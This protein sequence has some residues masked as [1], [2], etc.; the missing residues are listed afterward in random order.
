MKTDPW[1]VAKAKV[2]EML[3]D[4]K[5]HFIPPTLTFILGERERYAHT[6][7]M[8]LSIGAE[9][10]SLNRWILPQDKIKEALASVD[11]GVQPTGG[12]QNHEER[13]ARVRA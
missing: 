7:H 2:I 10:R 13:L 1:N 12:H 6:Y 11:A 8:L 4:G 9:G 5:E 3:I